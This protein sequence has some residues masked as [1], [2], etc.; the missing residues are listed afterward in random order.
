ML[1]GAV[2][3]GFVAARR[4]VLWAVIPPA[5]LT[6]LVLP[7]YVG[8]FPGWMVAGA[9]LGGAIGAGYSGV[10]PLLLTGLFPAAVRARCVGLVYHVG[11]VI[12]AGVPTAIAALNQYAGMSL[13]KSIGIMA[14][15]CQL[16]LVVALML[17]PRGA[18]AR[19]DKAPSERESLG[20]AAELAGGH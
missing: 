18:L 2:I 17:R 19:P 9:F 5:L 6:V 15:A 13:A 8:T 20:A 12:A 1:G 11:A 10:T 16:L 14:A 3:T 7:I 4:G